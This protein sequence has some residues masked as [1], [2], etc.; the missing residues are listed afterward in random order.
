MT[1][2]TY[3]FICLNCI[4]CFIYSVCRSAFF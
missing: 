4:Y 1:G 3:V 2:Y